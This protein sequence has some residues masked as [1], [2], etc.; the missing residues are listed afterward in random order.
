MKLK[1]F[2]VIQNVNDLSSSSGG[3]SKTVTYLSKELISA[4]IDLKIF[5]KFSHEIKN[6]WI[7]PEQNLVFYKTKNFIK[8]PFFEFSLRKALDNISNFKNLIIHDN[9]IWLPS[10][11]TIC[12]FAFEKK[13]KLLISPHGMLE[14]WSINYKKLKKNLAWKIYQKSN[15]LKADVIHACSEMEANNILKLGLKKPIAIIPNGSI[16]PTEFQ[17]HGKNLQKNLSLDKKFKYF[18]YLGRIHPKKNLLNLL[19]SVKDILHRE[20]KWKLII[21]GY[22]ELKYD[23]VLKKFINQN[24]LS[25]KVILLGP[26]EGVNLFYLYKKANFFILPSLSENFGLVVAEALNFGLPVISTKPTPWSILEKTNSGWWI[27]PSIEELSKAINKAINLD[28]NEYE[29]MSNNALTLSRNYQWEKISQSFITLY[30]WMLGQGL[31]PNFI[32]E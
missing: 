15:L 8:N 4:G 6:Q 20:T 32:I 25:N 13:I 10:N 14:P 28:L 30:K 29:K 21:A 12:K 3:P 1:S 27:E 24:N 9:G 19:I 23:L 11:N 26:V 31:K 5:S 7:I 22:P 17:S 16:N 18:L 2:S